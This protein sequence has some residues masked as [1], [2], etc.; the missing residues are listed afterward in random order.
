MKKTQERTRTNVVTP[1]EKNG[2]AKKDEKPQLHSVQVLEE[3]QSRSASQPLSEEMVEKLTTPVNTLTMSD[4]LA[5]CLQNEPSIRYVFEL[6]QKTREELL[7]LKGLGI[8]TVHEAKELLIELGFSDGMDLG[9][10]LGMKLDS[11]TLDRIRERI[12]HGDIWR[13]CDRELLLRNLATPL[14]N[15][16]SART[17]QLVGKK[18]VFELA[19]ETDVGLL[20]TKYFGVR[21]LMEVK[22]MLLDLNLSTGMQFDEKTPLSV[23][24]IIWK[25]DKV[26]FSERDIIILAQKELNDLLD[27]RHVT[28]GSVSAISE[29]LRLILY[30]QEITVCRLF[31]IRAVQK[32]LYKNSG[33]AKTGRDMIE[34]AQKE[35]NDLLDT[36]HVTP[37]SV[38]AISAALSEFG[39]LYK[40]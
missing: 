31:F 12:P 6:I 22:A 18:Y 32:T 4:R 34:Q 19:Q 9:T 39:M 35:L 14:E 33:R 38:S 23:K 27:T 29:A 20:R 5:N 26:R 24:S 2:F 25:R 15:L 36:G 17:V 13:T 21:C 16:L 1:Q 37:M 40:K 3:K 7:T 28:P 11:E 10:P 8:K 30:F